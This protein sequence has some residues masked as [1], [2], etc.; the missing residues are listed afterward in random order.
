M[1]VVLHVQSARRSKANQLPSA[2]CTYAKSS[3]L[4]AKSIAHGVATSCAMLQHRA[5]CCDTVHYVAIVHRGAWCVILQQGSPLGALQQS[6]K[7]VVR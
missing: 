6:E 7:A 4:R 2:N 1:T 3:C 5:L